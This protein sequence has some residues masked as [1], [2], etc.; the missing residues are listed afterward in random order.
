MSEPGFCTQCGSAMAATDAFCRRCGAARF[1]GSTA[2]AGGDRSPHNPS[3]PRNFGTAP[4][5][6][7]S[8]ALGIF[9]AIVILAATV[10]IGAGYFS[11]P[12]YSSANL[13]AGGSNDLGATQNQGGSQLFPKPY[14]AI[15]A[16]W[17][18]F[19]Y[20][21]R[22]T[23]LSP[24]NTSA[25][26]GNRKWAFTISGGNP[27]VYSS[28]AIGTDGTIY[29]GD[30]NSNFFA[31]NP[32]GTQKWAF[33]TGN[34]VNSSPAIGTDGTVYVADFDGN[35]YAVNRDG[36]RKWAFQTGALISTSSP[37]I[38]SD[39]TI[40]VGSSNNKFYAVNPDGTQKWVFAT[41]GDIGNSSPA[42]GA[43]GTIYVGS[44][45]NNLYALTDGGQGGV[46]K[47]WAFAAGG[48]VDS[49]PAVGADGT[50][51][52]GSADNNFYAVKPDG[53]QKWV[54][55]GA[56]TGG[57][58]AVGPDGTIYFGSGSPDNHLHA[59]T[60]NGASATQ[61]WAFA[62]GNQVGSSPAIGADGTNYFGS[63]DFKV[64]AVNPDGTQKWVFPTGSYVN[65]SP[66]IGSDGTIY[67]GSYDGNL[68]AIGDRRPAPSFAAAGL[69]GS[70]NSPNQ[71]RNAELQANCGPFTRVY[72]AGATFA[73]LCDQL[74]MKCAYV[75]DWEGHMKPCDS[76]AHDGSRVAS[77]QPTGANNGIG[78][79]PARL[80]SWPA[81]QPIQDDSD[82]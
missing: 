52:F 61:K 57:A 49:S 50:I 74:H 26:N 47:K 12:R 9:A 22:H 54:F 32:D 14:A 18:M 77:C 63:Q 71:D 5:A 68:Y 31:V 23:G 35:L 38:G 39:G 44:R 41:G 55:A 4:T 10:W 46:T 64:Y 36:T 72:A 15:S 11:S 25:N 79:P 75:C 7:P 58:P 56:S 70:T 65:S 59:I 53:T 42:I 13:M 73:Q 43:D 80:I 69:Y 6:A 28:P 66:A 45:D 67:I 8:A 33:A 27:A 51:Y 76:S 34:N 1:G 40:Y 37:A 62:T 19:H 60:D 30:S 24:Y 82:D 21:L 29:V 48:Q 17:P 78:M 2:S 20:N 3:A 81:P 16:A